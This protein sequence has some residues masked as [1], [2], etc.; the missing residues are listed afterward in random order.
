MNGRTKKQPNVVV[1]IADQLRADHLGFA[2][3]T[4]VQTP[5]LD[6][7]AAESIIF[8]EATVTNPTC[9]P[10]RAS[11]L[12]GRWPSAHGTRC[13]GI[14]VD[15]DASNMVKSLS[16][17][18]YQ[19]TAIGKLH[20]QNMGCDFE[21]VQRAEIDAIDPLLMDPSV[22]DARAPRGP[23]RWDM[24]EDMDAHNEQFIPLPDD[25][26]GYRNVDLVIGHGDRP[27]GH[28]VHWARERGLDPTAV[29]GPANAPRRLPGWDQVYQT[30]VPAALH[31]SSYVG[32]RAVEHLVQFGREAEPFFMF[33]SFPDPHHPFSPPEEYADMYSPDEVE[34]PLGFYQNHAKSPPHIRHMFEHRGEPNVD[35]TMTFAVDEAQYRQAV[36][37]QYGLI[38]LM[39]EQI[40]RI[41]TTLEET[42]LA[43]DTIV[44]FTSDHGDLFGD[45]GLILKHF[46]HYRAVTKVPLTIKA[47]GHRPGTSDALVST[48]DL[49][50]TLLDL[51]RT[52]PYRGIQG[53][54]LVPLLQGKVHSVR[55]ALIIEEDQPFG[56]PGLPGPVRTRSVLTTEGRLTKYFGTDIAELYDHETDREEL[57]NVAGEP[58]FKEL[59][60]RMTLAMLEGMAA[61][62][63]DGIAP[64]AAA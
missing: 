21:P 9:M 3:N 8:T 64:T 13:N 27:G 38:T 43:D 62:A 35:P 40:G 31:P 51:T 53:I 56:L 10:N 39:D 16:C 33:V 2:G 44:V 18:G 50:P 19:T 5:N 29:G 63:D 17:E 14:T 57:N 60:D 23:V 48:A 42:G 37:A 12:T 55:N 47:P 45:H 4:M 28:Y 34:L 61:L 6:K 20:H 32:E 36:T 30:A 49:A 41:L 59:Q 7:L 22:T 46:S 25:Y 1:I 58:E 26:Y 11:L 15:P 52:L 54:S 24:W